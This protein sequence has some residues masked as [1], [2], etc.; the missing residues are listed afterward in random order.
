MPTKF[1]SR[2][3]RVFKVER[4]HCTLE[5]T[6]EE[7][8]TSSSLKQDWKRFE[9]RIVA[10]III[11]S[12]SRTLL[13][14]LTSC[15]VLSIIKKSILITRWCSWQ[16][17]MTWTGWGGTWAWSTMLWWLA[18]SYTPTY[19]MMMMMMMMMILILQWVI[20]LSCQVVITASSAR[21]ASDH[22]IISNSWLMMM[23][24]QFG[25]WSAFL[26]G[27]DVWT[28]YGPVTSNIISKSN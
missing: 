8:T 15:L 6:S 3:L 28:E 4:N 25:L 7:Q 10:L 9:K 19:M 18:V 16:S 20:W 5:C 14:E 11:F 23:Q 1:W 12:H 13:A 21:Q 24:G 22:N 27:G 17:V 26:A 2:Y